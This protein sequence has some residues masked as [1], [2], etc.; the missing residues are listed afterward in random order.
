MKESILIG[1]KACLSA[2]SFGASKLKGNPERG[3]PQ[4]DWIWLRREFSD[5]RI[6]LPVG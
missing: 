5:G 2:P 4:P 3:Q 6:M 1:M